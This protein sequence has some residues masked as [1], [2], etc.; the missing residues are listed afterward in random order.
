M[1]V[2]YN[3]DNINCP[4]AELPTRRGSTPIGRCSVTKTIPLTRGY[5]CVVDDEDYEWL[6][7]WKWCADGYRRGF[8]CYATRKQWDSG[9]LIYVAMHR[10]I[11]GAAPGEIVDHIDGDGLNN[12]RANLRIVDKFGH[13]RNR[14]SARGASSGYLGVS[15]HKDGKWQ[16]IIR[17]DG[18]NRYLG[19]FESEVEAALAYD[20]AARQIC[21]EFARFNF[22]LKD[23]P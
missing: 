6:N 11:I 21:G 5:V 22:P 3:E 4:A 1:L 12:T 19:L 17:V 14:R 18:R 20:D 23:S 2:A 8:T 10:I 13:A 16:A 9:K 7:Q 15:L